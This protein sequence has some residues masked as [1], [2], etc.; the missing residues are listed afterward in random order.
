MFFIW[1]TDVLSAAKKK[2]NAKHSN[3]NFD[4]KDDFFSDDCLEL[5]FFDTLLK[6]DFRI[7]TDSIYKCFEDFFI[8]VNEQYGQIVT[9]YNNKIEVYDS[10]LIGIEALQEIVLQ[11]RDKAVYTKAFAF[12]L[13][14]YKNISSELLTQKLTDMKLDLLQICTDHI[15]HG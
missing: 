7:F 3:G 13:K 12:L 14:I 4:E 15:K 6:L 5:L 11:V 9:S 1:C 10:K 2:Q 8:H